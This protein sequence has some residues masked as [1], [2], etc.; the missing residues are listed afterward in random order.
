M[1][2]V[3]TVAAEALGLTIAAVTAGRMPSGCS[4]MTAAI[5]VK[6]S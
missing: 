5:G 6:A 2:R 3:M 4:A 1:V